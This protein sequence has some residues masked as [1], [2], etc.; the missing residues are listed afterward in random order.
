MLAP[1]TPPPTTT[2]SAVRT[3]TTSP[4]NSF[5]LAADLPRECGERHRTGRRPWREYPDLAD[6]LVGGPGELKGQ[7]GTAHPALAPPHPDA[8]PRLDLV[9]RG[10][11][12]A[13]CLER[14]G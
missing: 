14:L 1:F 7:R 13:H 6:G 2:T 5:D 4:R 10:R 12:L 3:I 8:R 9:H 11:A